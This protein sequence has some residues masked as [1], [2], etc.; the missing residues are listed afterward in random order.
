MR[1]LG[2][3]NLQQLVP[4][5]LYETTAKP[6]NSS[7]VTRCCVRCGFHW[8]AA[9]AAHRPSLPGY[10]F[11][12]REHLLSRHRVSLLSNEVTLGNPMR[13]RRT[14]TKP[15][16]WIALCRN[17]ARAADIRCGSSRPSPPAA[18]QG[19]RPNPKGSTAHDIV[20][21]PTIHPKRAIA[22]SQ[23]WCSAHCARSPPM[24]HPISPIRYCLHAQD[25]RTDR[26]V[27]ARDSPF[28]HQRHAR[29]R[30]IPIALVA[31][32]L[33]NA[34]GF[35]PWSLSDARPPRSPLPSSSGRHPK[36]FTIADIGDGQVC[37]RFG[38]RSIHSL[39]SRRVGPAFEHPV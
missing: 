20:G 13:S 29:S 35:L 11:E 31:P 39:T 36:R 14:R 30:K 2:L 33:T 34:R 28:D 23:R 1:S 10:T 24:E 25:A 22:A 5:Y 32:Q 9:S 17:P 7:R 18:N 6:S 38:S 3:N 12:L 16:Q 4:V 21:A 26:A 15:Q 27:A 37:S 19:T 8:R